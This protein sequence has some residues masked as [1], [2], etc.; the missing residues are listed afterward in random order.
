MKIIFDE[1]MPE[2]IALD[3]IGHDCDHVVVLGWAGIKNG[4][5]LSRSEEAGFQ[6][7]LTFDKGIPNQQ[8]L[9]GRRIS[10]IVLKPEGQGIRAVRALAGDVLKAL[11]GIQEGEVRVVSNRKSGGNTKT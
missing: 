2:A 5:L 1:N 10:V 7:L 9:Q 6:V 3:L 11:D 8:K 4:A